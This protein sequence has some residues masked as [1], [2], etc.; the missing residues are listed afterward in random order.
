MPDI[1]EQIAKPNS[2]ATL[3]PLADAQAADLGERNDR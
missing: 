2:I 3:L 1:A